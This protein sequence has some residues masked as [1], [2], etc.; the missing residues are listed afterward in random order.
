MSGLQDAVVLDDGMRLT[1]GV[2]LAWKYRSI[3]PDDVRRVTIPVVDHTTSGGAAL[4]RPRPPLAELLTA[5]LA[6]NG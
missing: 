3:E 2:A 1:R 5:E 4:L 6:E